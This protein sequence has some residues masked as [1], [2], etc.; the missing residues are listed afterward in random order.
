MRSKMKWACFELTVWCKGQ[1]FQTYSHSFEQE[2]PY[3]K[4]LFCLRSLD[5]AQVI[6]EG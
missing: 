5:A 4:G 2:S 1:Y 6:Y 3:K